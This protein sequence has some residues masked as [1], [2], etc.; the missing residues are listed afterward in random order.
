MPVRPRTPAY[1]REERCS[2]ADRLPVV[3]QELYRGL[4]GRVAAS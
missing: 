4:D 2:A 3:Q 1:L